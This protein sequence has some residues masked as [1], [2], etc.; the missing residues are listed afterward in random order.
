MVTY[1]VSKLNG[2]D[3]GLDES[4]QPPEEVGGQGEPRIQTHISS[5]NSLMVQ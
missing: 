5:L 4:P 1:H 3:S 2:G